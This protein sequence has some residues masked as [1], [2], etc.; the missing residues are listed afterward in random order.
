MSTQE[1]LQLME[2]AVNMYAGWTTDNKVDLILAA[3]EKMKTAIE[4]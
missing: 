2:K 4:K 1:K 3:Y